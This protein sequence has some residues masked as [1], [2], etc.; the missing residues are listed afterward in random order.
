MLSLKIGLLLIMSLVCQ[1]IVRGYSR[2]G[3]APRCLSWDFIEAMLL[4]LNSP[5]HFV[6][7]IMICVTTH[8]FSLMMNGGPV[9]YFPRKGE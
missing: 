2:E 5:P 4:H 3:G 1:S 9:S 7:K 6:Q 8:R